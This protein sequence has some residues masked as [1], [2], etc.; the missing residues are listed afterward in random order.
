M[1]LAIDEIQACLA[2][3]ASSVAG[4]DFAAV[5]SGLRIEIAQSVAE[6]H[7]SIIAG[8]ALIFTCI[9]ATALD[10]LR[11]DAHAERVWH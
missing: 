2:N 9:L 4:S 5:L 8:L 10:V 6:Q 11:R 3:R 1:A 7:I